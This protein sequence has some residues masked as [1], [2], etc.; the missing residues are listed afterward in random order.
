MAC[1]LRG[2][3]QRVQSDQVDLQCALLLHG[4]GQGQVAER[5]KGHRDLGAHRTHQG[6]L[7]KA[8]KDVHNDGVISLDVV[9]PGL[10]RHHLR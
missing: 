10:L 8:M 4:Q 2:F 1:Y 5:I 9:L 3:G 6:G 7:E